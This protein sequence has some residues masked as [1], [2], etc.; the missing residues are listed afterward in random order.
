MVNNIEVYASSIRYTAGGLMY[1][2]RIENLGTGA[3][4][5]WLVQGP[6][7][8][9]VAAISAQ[10]SVTLSSS[11]A[12][13]VVAST[14]LLDEWLSYYKVSPTD[15]SPGRIV[16]QTRIGSEEVERKLIQ[17]AINTGSSTTPN[18]GSYPRSAPAAFTASG[19]RVD[20]S[21][22][23]VPIGT[24]AGSSMSF[25]FWAPPVTA[26]YAAHV[27]RTQLTVAVFQVNSLW[28][29]TVSVYESNTNVLGTGLKDLLVNGLKVPDGFSPDG[30]L[31]LGMV[32]GTDFDQCYVNAESGIELVQMDSTQSFQAV[33]MFNVAPGVNNTPSY[34]STDI[35][36]SQ[37]VPMKFQLNMLISEAVKALWYQ[38]EP[39]KLPPPETETPSGEPTTSKTGPTVAGVGP[40]LGT[41]TGRVPA[42]SSSTKP[43]G[44][45]AAQSRIVPLG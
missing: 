29:G 8:M 34:G 27:T 21:S 40:T 43:T 7:N 28:T 33:S 31:L 39:V 22:I 24:P 11:Q 42:P 10:A 32:P 5:P 15:G 41:G 38:V 20:T 2:N 17:P 4:P 12:Q 9:G 25:K 37:T 30:V 3:S 19:S 6:P 16:T 26:T 1:R 23:M 44:S 35:P 14:D 36:L 45:G 13:A 18:P